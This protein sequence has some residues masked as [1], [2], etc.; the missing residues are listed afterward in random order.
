MLYQLWYPSQPEVNRL[1]ASLIAQHG[2]DIEQRLLKAAYLVN[3]YNLQFVPPPDKAAGPPGP[4]FARFNIPSQ[5]RPDR[6]YVVESGDICTCPDFINRSAYIGKRRVCKH[7]L[8]YWL[9]RR[10][11]CNRVNDLIADGEIEIVSN[12]KEIP[13]YTAVGTLPKSCPALQV[14]PSRSGDRWIIPHRRF[15]GDV[16]RV[17]AWLAR[18]EAILRQLA[19]EEADAEI[20]A[21]SRALVAAFPL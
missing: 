21:R 9:W 7:I 16:I 1:A 15:D 2:P 18:R 4:L 3:P 20:E 5:T 17:A 8:A 12:G 11:V 6:H 19:K 14:E 10:L 13:S